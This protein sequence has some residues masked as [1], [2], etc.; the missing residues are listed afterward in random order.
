MAELNNLIIEAID[1]RIWARA[2]IPLALS[3]QEQEVGVDDEQRIGAL[4]ASSRRALDHW[5]AQTLITIYGGIEDAI[6]SMCSGLYPLFISSNPDT[7]KRMFEQNRLRNRELR[8]RGE[9]STEAA[10]VLTRLTKSLADELVPTPSQ[11][12]PKDMPAG[13]RWEKALKGIRLRPMPGRPLPDELRQTLNEF[14]AIR[15]VILHRM[16]RIDQ[17]ALDQVLY[18]PWKKIDELVVIDDVLYRLYVA[19]LTA[20]NLEVTDRVRNLLLRLP[21]QIEINDWKSMVPAGG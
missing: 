2:G 8:Q 1:Y 12:P 16:G 20:Y 18:G 21:P 4:R 3:Q 10:Q 13:D 6:E 19:A 17:R 14:G 11:M 9:L 15:N 7:K 5:N